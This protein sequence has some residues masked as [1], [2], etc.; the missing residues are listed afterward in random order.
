MYKKS[1][2]EEARELGAKLEQ[3]F[4]R[5]LNEN[6]IWTMVKFCK[7]IRRSCRHNT[8]FNGAFSAAFPY[9]SF[10][11]VS[12]TIMN[13][14]RKGQTY[15]GLQVTVNGVAPTDDNEEEDE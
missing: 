11:Q 3:L 1:Y 6:E 13:G 4:G 2:T 10:R 12:K 5:K 9:A 15:M 7:V 8:A 14:P